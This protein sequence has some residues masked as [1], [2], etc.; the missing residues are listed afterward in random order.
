MKSSAIRKTIK[1]IVNR[2][3]SDAPCDEASRIG[4][5]SL[6]FTKIE[7]VPKFSETIANVINPILIEEA[8]YSSSGKFK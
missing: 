4:L 6:K 5:F 8:I 2:N 7:P 3:V 1:I